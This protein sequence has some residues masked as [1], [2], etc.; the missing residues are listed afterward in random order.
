MASPEDNLRS[1]SDQL[2]LGRMKPLDLLRGFA[3]IINEL[4]RRG[5]SRTKNNPVADYTEWLVSRRLNLDLE[6]NSRSGYDALDRAGARYEIKGR[7]TSH[8]NRAVQLSAIRNL[9]SRHFEYLVAVV[10]NADFSI[11]YA[12]K[13]PIEVVKESASYRKHVN[14]H[15]L[16]LRPTIMDDPRVEDI[17]GRLDS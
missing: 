16:T 3:A 6:G 4:D 15:I 14:A 2:G 11:Q 8:G 17:T 12:A 1:I 7:R 10:Y 5:I 13:I 9:D